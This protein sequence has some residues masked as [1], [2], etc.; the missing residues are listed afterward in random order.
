MGQREYDKL[1][2]WLDFSC[3][4]SGPGTGRWGKRQLSKA[5]RRFARQYCRDGERA[6]RH[7]GS[8]M[9]WEGEIN[10]KFW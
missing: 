4:W 1:P 9:H 6:Y 5:R 3:V 7:M 10:W 8:L 2:S